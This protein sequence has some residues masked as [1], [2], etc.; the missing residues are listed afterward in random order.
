MHLSVSETWTTSAPAPPTTRSYG[1][2]SGRCLCSTLG[3]SPSSCYLPVSS[4][5]SPGSAPRR[6]LTKPPVTSAKRRSSTPATPSSVR[7]SGKLRTF[8][9]PPKAR[10][11]FNKKP[12]SS[13][14]TGSC[15]TPDRSPHLRQKNSTPPLPPSNR[16]LSKPSAK[17][18][19]SSASRRQHALL[20]R[21]HY[22]E[23]CKLSRFLSLG[24]P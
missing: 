1:S 17:P 18:E 13:Q 20:Q 15:A 3:S 24:R 11:S 8:H 16:Q 10:T 19:F 5:R 4:V 14:A 22:S 2:A 9:K 12:T 23:G 7:R 6:D 21:C